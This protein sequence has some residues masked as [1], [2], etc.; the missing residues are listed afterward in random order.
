MSKNPN[1]P[2]ATL[3]RHIGQ[4]LAERR[5]ALAISVDELAAR[6]GVKAQILRDMEAG[7]T[8]VASDLIFELCRTLDV[9]PPYFF[10]SPAE[11]FDLRKQ[12]QGFQAPPDD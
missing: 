6:V 9:K 1:M 12:G 8:R 2:V 7:N 5:I 10:P 3:D 4:R 11:V